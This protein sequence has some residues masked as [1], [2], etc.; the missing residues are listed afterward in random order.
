MIVALHCGRRSWDWISTSLCRGRNLLDFLEEKSS[1]WRSPN[2]KTW[3]LRI[4]PTMCV[5]TSTKLYWNMQ[6]EKKMTAI[7]KSIRQH[8]FIKTGFRV[9][10]KWNYHCMSTNKQPDCITRPSRAV[11]F[12]PNIFAPT[13]ASNT[14]S[15]CSLLNRYRLSLLCPGTFFGMG[16]RP[17]VHAPAAYSPCSWTETLDGAFTTS[18]HSSCNGHQQPQ[19]K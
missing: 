8:T 7:S 12:P 2:S 17:E 14:K 10:L 19:P 6:Q 3:H 18:P 13:I 5:C 11:A 9:A 1:L 16:M 4:C 15:K